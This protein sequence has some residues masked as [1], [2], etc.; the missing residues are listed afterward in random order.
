MFVV[1]PVCG[2]ERDDCVSGL[3]TCTDIG[4]GTYDCTC[5]DGYIGNGK[6]CAGSYIYRFSPLFLDLLKNQVS[7]CGRNK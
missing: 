3:S 7:R 4:S 1:R 6:F 5:N 2:T